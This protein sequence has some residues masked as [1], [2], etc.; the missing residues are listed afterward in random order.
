MILV[1]QEKNGNKLKK[2]ISSN[3]CIKI[4]LVAFFIFLLVAF[5]LIIGLFFQVNKW[6]I[7]YVLKKKKKDNWKH[8][9]SFLKI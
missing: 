1:D 9:L 6:I 3:L 5:G 4:I 2:K 8:N 7:L